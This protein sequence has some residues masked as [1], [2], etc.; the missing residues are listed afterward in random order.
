[1]SYK[2]DLTKLF[3]DRYKEPKSDA[4]T[5]DTKRQIHEYFATGRVPD[6]F[7]LAVLENDLFGAL[8]HG[9]DQIGSL[10]SIMKHLHENAP[11]NSHGSSQIVSAWMEQ[12]GL[13]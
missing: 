3:P 1:M 8:G 11:P 6:Q 4:M 2:P 7:V 5:E 12:G 13:S 9:Y 10:F